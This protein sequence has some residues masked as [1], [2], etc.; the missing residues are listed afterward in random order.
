[1]TN[2]FDKKYYKPKKIDE[3]LIGEL[4][5]IIENIDIDLLTNFSLQKRIPLSISDNKGNNLIHHV[6]NNSDNSINEIRKLNI[7]KYLVNNNVNPNAP[8]EEN[9]TPLHLACEKQQINLINYLIHI[10]VNI[11]HIDN[12]GN[13]CLHY[14]TCGKIVTW[15]D[16]SKKPLI[17]KPKINVSKKY[18]ALSI[19][20]K[21]VWEQVKDSQFLKLINNSLEVSIGSSEDSINIVKDFDEKLREISTG[22]FRPDD[23]FE[24]LKSI[25]GAKI[26]KFQ[27][28]ILNRWGDFDNL[29]KSIEIHEK[30]LDSWPQIEDDWY[31]DGESTRKIELPINEAVI[32]GSDYIKELVE[33]TN[34]AVDNLIEILSDDSTIVPQAQFGATTAK[35]YYHI[36]QMGGAQIGD[37]VYSLENNESWTDIKE[38]G[39]KVWIL[40]SGRIAKKK[41]ENIKWTT[42]GMSKTLNSMIN[43]D[44]KINPQFGKE[45]ENVKEIYDKINKLILDNNKY[46]IIQNFDIEDIYN[47]IKNDNYFDGE[48]IFTDYIEDVGFAVEVEFSTNLE[49]LE[50]LTKKLLGQDT[51]KIFDFQNSLR[52]SGLSEIDKDN[53]EKKI[54]ILKKYL[55]SKYKKY[56]RIL[57]KKLTID[58]DTFETNQIKLKDL[59]QKK[60]V[61]TISKK[62]TEQ[63]FTQKKQNQINEYLDDKIKEYE[64]IIETVKDKANEFINSLSTPAAGAAAP[65]GALGPPVGPGIPVGGV[66]GVPGTPSTTI[67][68][69]NFRLKIVSYLKMIGMISDELNFFKRK[70]TT[71]RL[72]AVGA[73]PGGLALGIPA[74]PTTIIFTE[75]DKLIL[76]INKSLKCIENRI[77]KL[78]KDILELIKKA[79][80]YTKKYNINSNYTDANKK[81]VTKILENFKILFD[82]FNFVRT[83][84]KEFKSGL[85]VIVNEEDIEFNRIKLDFNETE[86]AITLLENNI[87][88]NKKQIYEDNIKDLELKLPKTTDSTKIY[89]LNQQIKSFKYLYFKIKYN[90]IQDSLKLLLETIKKSDTKDLSKLTTLYEERALMYEEINNLGNIIDDLKSIE[91]S[92]D[93]IN[94]FQKIKEELNNSK[95]NNENDI[96]Q[97]DLSINQFEERKKDKEFEKEIL[98]LEIEYLTKKITDKNTELATATPANKAKLTKEKRQLEKEKVTKENQK[99]K[100]DNKELI[101]IQIE[102]I[103]LKATGKVLELRKNKIETKINNIDNKITIQTT[104]LE[105]SKA[106]KEAREERIDSLNQEKV[107]ELT[108]DQFTSIKQKE[109][110][111]SKEKEEIKEE[112]I[113]GT[114]EKKYYVQKGGDLKDDI[115]TLITQ[116]IKAPIHPFGYA[117]DTIANLLTDDD[118]KEKYNKITDILTNYLQEK[119]IAIN[120][121]SNIMD[122]DKHI[123]VGGSRDIILKEINN[124]KFLN[125]YQIADL[126][127]LYIYN[128][129]IDRS[130]NDVNTTDIYLTGQ[131]QGI[132]DCY[133]ILNFYIFYLILFLSKKE[134]NIFGLYEVNVSQITKLEQECVNSIKSG[135]F[136]NCN[137]NRFYQISKMIEERKTNSGLDFVPNNKNYLIQYIYE[138]KCEM[139]CIKS[140]SHLVNSQPKISQTFIYLLTAIQNNQTNLYLSFLQA[141]RLHY[142]K[143]KIDEDDDEY[144]EIINW[145]LVLLNDTKTNIFDDTSNDFKPNIDTGGNLEILEVLLERYFNNTILGEP[146]H[147]PLTKIS[148]REGKKLAPCELV[149]LAIMKYYESMEQKPLLQHV[150]D[151]ISVIRYYYLIKNKTTPL[152]L[153]KKK[154]KSLY[155]SPDCYKKNIL[156]KTGNPATVPFKSNLNY[157]YLKTVDVDNKYKNIFDADIAVQ[158]ENLTEYQ[159]PSRI[160]FYLTSKES[161]FEKSRN[162]GRSSTGKDHI[163]NIKKLIEANHFGLNYLGLLPKVKV[164]DS[165]NVQVRG[166]QQNFPLQL[167]LG[168]FTTE[169]QNNVNHPYYD[170]SDSRGD[171]DDYTRYRPCYTDNYKDF[172]R[173]LVGIIINLESAVKKYFK[174]YIKEFQKNKETENYSKLVTFLYPILV[175][176]NNHKLV[177]INLCN[178]M[179]L[180]EYQFNDSFLNEVVSN[181]NKINT[182]LFFIYYLKKQDSDRLKIPQ[183][184]YHQLSTNSNPLTVFDYTLRDDDDNYEMNQYPDE[185]I[186][187]NDINPPYE[188]DGDIEYDDDKLFEDD[189]EHKYT[190]IRSKVNPTPDNK[191]LSFYNIIKRNLE[192]GDYFKIN[193]IIKKAY[194]QT[195]NQK[196]PPSIHNN[197]NKFYKYNLI[198]ILI[199]KAKDLHIIDN[200]NDD[201]NYKTIF[202]P[203]NNKKVFNLYKLVLNLKLAGEVIS[204]YLKNEVY[205]IG[206]KIMEEVIDNYPVTS[207]REAKINVQFLLEDK[208][209]EVDLKES[210]TPDN[211]S[212]VTDGIAGQPK[213]VYE[214]DITNFSAKKIYNKK[215]D[216]II[217][218]EDYNRLEPTKA[219]LK[220]VISKDIIMKLLKS[221]VN[222]NIRNMNNDLA[223]KYI[224]KQLNYKKIEEIINNLDVDNRGFFKNY[225]KKHFNDYLERKFKNH[226]EKFKRGKDIIDRNEKIKEQIKNFVNTQYNEVKILSED[227]YD[228]N[229]L[230]GL[231]DSFI[232]CNIYSQNIINNRNITNFNLRNRYLNFKTLSIN[233]KIRNLNTNKNL[234]YLINNTNSIK[235][236][237]KYWQTQYALPFPL[238]PPSPIP[239]PQLP[240][241]LLP[242]PPPPIRRPLPPPAPAPLPFNDIDFNTIIDNIENYFTEKY[243]KI[244]KIPKIPKRGKDTIPNIFKKSTNQLLLYLTKQFICVPIEII[245]RRI[246]WAQL[247]KF[248]FSTN[249]TDSQ[250]IEDKIEMIEYILGTPKPRDA[251]GIDITDEDVEKFQSKNIQEILYNDV[252][253]RFVKYI[254]NFFDTEEDKIEYM[255]FMNDDIETTLTKFLDAILDTSPVKFND[256]VKEL[257][258]EQVIPY[259]KD[260]IPRIIKNW[261]ICIE[262]VFLYTINFYR[263]VRCYQLI[264]E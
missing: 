3:K 147:T 200:D 7:L 209:F 216:F 228:Y 138:L 168:W 234:S 177:I 91:E 21:K 188:E 74:G 120:Q 134:I 263:I 110:D 192:N 222:I 218:P 82:T 166:G 205:R 87:K 221:K 159:I 41:N 244:P 176:I 51:D 217:Y 140:N 173:R 220:V 130:I 113:K 182:N 178:D 248:D 55:I 66:A 80:Q 43:K 121:V 162:N 16:K 115:Q 2:R 183:F 18:K 70:I 160:N 235:K 257:F 102:I 152:T 187:L 167:Q 5:N 26:D 35:K 92:S 172:L 204:L 189:N 57:E 34:V 163:L 136:R 100:I 254:T 256:K 184:L 181:I 207:N 253:D 124:R 262:N 67:D 125:F 33:G 215:N 210:M 47:K 227:N 186:K 98:D 246:L 180:F 122:W 128:I 241:P 32:K 101:D 71:V 54:S 153:T 79:D 123:F 69:D 132:R 76:E 4:F 68:T 154:L 195:S 224:V 86:K 175:A 133:N 190:I 45:I 232:I 179:K 212:T 117:G 233:N 38:D 90:D 230:R 127:Y 191:I 95:E 243:F 169:V 252:A 6:I 214:M 23:K 238:P 36:N 185:N 46:G 53:I 131:Y 170:I 108:Y 157:T 89:N 156:I 249:R 52:T 231:E 225:M 112:A 142:I 72:P 193:R 105:S 84:Y 146:K 104:D 144:N 28:D 129:I 240:P 31:A 199:D 201:D 255:E 59:N 206:A 165:I 10:G 118:M 96:T 20:K 99:G 258:I 40:D 143:E 8:N 198:R 106:S 111:E 226:L 145:I 24:Y 203:T 17:K 22:E 48:E 194:R 245:L 60:I 77:N 164:D 14:M 141:S 109:Q 19:L 88:D 29:D 65:P 12:Y 171:S 73:P 37:S 103:K 135:R 126:T 259:F 11:N 81:T 264:N 61:L 139:E 44:I 148:I 15:K 197:L 58:K 27:K 83:F 116:I 119:K 247:D 75:L 161:D 25:Q 229:I 137:Q 260:H 236:Y 242:P 239:R 42:S 64:K 208:P 85:N 174:S 223:L 39:G 9:K 62:T 213:S 114:T 202:G 261:Q 13:T 158:L 93:K 251:A 196:L 63:E 107:E 150:V 94:K 1:M 250:K 78:E 211:F 56:G 49:K 151:T 149:S 237:L 50:E 155:L 219:M 30:L 97:N